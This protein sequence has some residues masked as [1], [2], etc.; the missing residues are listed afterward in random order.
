MSQ[1]L[2][3]NKLQLPVTYS[4]LLP[5]HSLHKKSMS[6][7]FTSKSYYP[8]HYIHYMENNKCDRRGRWIGW[9]HRVWLVGRHWGIGGCEEGRLCMRWICTIRLINNG[10]PYRCLSSIGYI[11]IHKDNYY[12]QTRVT[13]IYIVILY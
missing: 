7:K 4:W 6:Y 3:Y 13:L 5:W 10:G 9:K 8:L 12:I 2:A 1:N 11:K